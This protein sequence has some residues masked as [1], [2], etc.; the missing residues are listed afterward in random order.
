MSTCGTV[1]NSPGFYKTKDTGVIDTNSKK[2]TCAFDIHMIY[3]I[4]T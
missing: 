3:N 4:P 1:D 2:R